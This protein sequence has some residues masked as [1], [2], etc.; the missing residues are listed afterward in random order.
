MHAS[1]QPQQQSGLTDSSDGRVECPSLCAGR[2]GFVEMRS[3]ELAS[4]AMQLDKVD[5]CGRQINVGRPKGY[6]EP[7]GGAAPAATLNAAQ[8]FAA[9]LAR[10]HSTV[11]LLENMLLAYQLHDDRERNEVRLF[12]ELLLIASIAQSSFLSIV[13]RKL[14][15][16]HG[17]GMLRRKKH[18]GRISKNDEHTYSCV[19]VII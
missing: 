17:S 4:S 3:E 13:L 5:V 9:S 1:K 10:R 6:V 8:V 7:P 16:T 19:L 15:Y 12:L 2:F 18:E 14:Q 11:L